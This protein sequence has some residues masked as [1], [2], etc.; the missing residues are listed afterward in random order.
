MIPRYRPLA[1]YSLLL[2]AATGIWLAAALAGATDFP[3]LWVAA[4]CV[5]FNLFVFQFGIPSPWV[6]LT[7]M[8]RLPQVG[9]LLVLSPPVA[10]AIC[11]T[12]SFLWPLFNRGYSHGSST[13]ATI[14][15]FHNAAMAGLMVLA[16]GYAYELAGGR[17]PLDGFGIADLLPLAAL[18]ITMQLVN[19]LCMAFF[20]YFDGRDVRALFRPIY[21][22]MDLIFVPA[23]V[24]AALLYNAHHP[25]TFALFMVLM[26]VFVLSVHGM[27]RALTAEDAERSPF[28]RLF[29]AGRALHGARRIE[30]LGDRLLE[31]LRPLLRF[32]D[33]YLVLADHKQRTLDFRVHEQHGE[34]Q[35]GMRRP[36]DTGLFGIVVNRGEPLLVADWRRAPAQLRQ[37][38]LE[39]GKET[40]SVIVMPLV[41][42]GGVI[43]LVSVQHT[44]AHVYSKADL[45]LLQ[46]LSEH[47]AAAVAD[48]RAFEDLEDYRAR[49][50]ERVT[51]RTAE[52]EKAARD[53]ER[54]IAA[55]REQGR[56][57]ERAARE[58][59]LTGVANRRHFMQRL[60]AEIEVA[61]ATGQPLTVAIADL[62]RFKLVNDSLGHGVGDDALRHS[63][64]LMLSLCRDSD[65]VARIGGEEFALILPGMART[66]AA[67]FCERLRGAIESHE[68][69]LVH[70]RLRMT[71]SIGVWQWNGAADAD[72][73]L[74]AADAQLYR[75]K[76]AGRN[77]VA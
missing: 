9:L 37:R 32:D 54:L 16:A 76:R 64:G 47:L 56:A 5:A 40:G 51:E 1:A 66:D 2:A 50:E 49:L 18:G 21:T 46:R 61:Q 68:W 28:A 7:S 10:A 24:L 4:L 26:A 30:E 25:A 6:G 3:P 8:E 38:A 43:G 27:G 39:T 52:L 20:Y 53:K 11:A 77:R 31:E 72:A 73:L 22:V 45:N 23:G 36:L 65:L 74:E 75:A 69:R 34:R 58:D 29:K 57:L 70:P 48:A 67:A 41:H 35:P 13:L 14:R 63:A 60:A 71:I 42:D 62:D 59:P 33:F 15:A 12:A 19:E 55:L 17:H 44:E